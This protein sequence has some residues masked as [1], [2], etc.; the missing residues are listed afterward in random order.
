MEGE[1]NPQSFRSRLAEPT[2]LGFFGPLS[3]G[4][5]AG[6]FFS[7]GRDATPVILYVVVATGVQARFLFLFLYTNSGVRSAKEMGEQRNGG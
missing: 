4:R 2:G 6:L 1:E 3:T 5:T 7:Y